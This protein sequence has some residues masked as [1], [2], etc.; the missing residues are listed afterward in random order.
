MRVRR[1]RP[2]GSCERGHTGGAD[3]VMAEQVELR[4]RLVG[5]TGFISPDGVPFDTEADGGQALA[6]F[7]GRACYQSWEKAV[8]ATATNAGFLEHVLTVGHLS[9]LEHASVTFY[10]TGISRGAAH[11]LIRHRHFSV[12]QLSPRAPA[13]GFVA[14]AD[15]AA[16]QV[17]RFAAAVD[18]AGRAYRDLLADL[19][20]DAGDTP[21]SVVR[22]KQARQAAAGLR[23]GR[24]R[25]RTGRHRELPQLASFHR[26]QGDRC[27]RRRAPHPGRDGP[28]PA[29]GRGAT[30]VRRL[31]DQH[32]ARR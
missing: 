3:A 31:Q 12:S 18:T 16:D 28:G 24:G 20:S 15:L 29:A 5:R 8:P 4:V 30:R 21:G 27:C 9:V 19:Q 26:D 22:R 6:E 10:L 14:P 11:E 7:A 32:V 25:H 23:P 17:E 1:P 2:A 13:Q